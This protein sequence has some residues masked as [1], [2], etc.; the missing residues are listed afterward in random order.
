[1]TGLLLPKPTSR[2]EIHLPPG[3][4]ADE[5]GWVALGSQE[6]R[7]PASDPVGRRALPAPALA[8]DIT[9]TQGIVSS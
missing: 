2:T 8:P 9:E 5:S 3:N 1:M 4:S 6:P 7:G